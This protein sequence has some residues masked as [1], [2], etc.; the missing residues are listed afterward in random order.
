MK[1]LL[2]E[3]IKLITCNPIQ[4]LQSDVDRLNYLVSLALLTH[5]SSSIPVAPTSSVEHS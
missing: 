2:V 3:S 5:N 1:I 4:L